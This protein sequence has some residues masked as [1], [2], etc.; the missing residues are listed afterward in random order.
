MVPRDGYSKEPLQPGFL[1]ACPMCLRWR[2]RRCSLVSSGFNDCAWHQRFIPWITLLA[3]IWTIAKLLGSVRHWR[4][5]IPVALVVWGLWGVSWEANGQVCQVCWDHDRPRWSH[6]QSMLLPKVWLSDCVTSRFTRFLCWVLLAPSA[7]PTRQ[8]SRLRT[9]PLSVQLQDR[10]TLY[11]PIFLELAL[12]VAL[13]LTWW[14]SRPRENPNGPWAQL[15][16]YF[17][18]LLTGEKEFLA[19]SMACSTANA[20]DIVCRLVRDGKLD[21]APQNKK[22][23]YA[24]GLLRAKLYVQACKVPGPISRYRVADILLHMKLVSGASRPG[25]TVGVLRILCMDYAQLKDFTL[26]SMIIRAVLDARV[27]PTLSLSLQRVPS[28][29]RKMYILFGDRLL[30][31]REETIFCT[32]S[33]PGCSC[34]ASSMASR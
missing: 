12:C 11:F 14:A 6:S 1:A 21:E 3:S 15:R 4:A 13:V 27:N 29:V 22:Q 20:F 5:S 30:C 25:L 32:T 10:T 8:P 19:P 17:L 24:T 28:F 18:S 23:K 9:M 2:P 31:F 7:H 16:S 26:K 33:S 34:E